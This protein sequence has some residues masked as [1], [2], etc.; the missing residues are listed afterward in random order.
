MNSPSQPQDRLTASVVICAYTLDRC[1]DIEA[2]LCAL[3]KQSVLPSEVLLIVDHN[4]QLE[5]WA[6]EQARKIACFPVEVLANVHKQGL[7]G[8]RNC[9]VAAAS[10]D[11]VVFLDDDAKPDRSWLAKL[12]SCYRDEAVIGVGGA[13]I[14][15]WP[16]RAPSWF[17]DEFAWVIGCSYEGMPKQR[18]EI[19]NFIGCNM[20][21][22]RAVFTVVA[23]FSEDLGRVGT[24]PLG[25]EETELCIRVR[26]AFPAA[27]LLYEPAAIVHHRVTAARTGFRY[28]RRRC[29]AEGLSKAA[30]TAM[31][32]TESGLA[33]ERSYLVRTLPKAL[34]R[35]VLNPR[36][37]A[38]GL[39]LIAGTGCT[40]A[41]FIRGR[42]TS[43]SGTLKT[44]FTPGITAAKL[45]PSR[46]QAAPRQSS[47]L[48]PDSTSQVS[49]RP[50]ED[51]AA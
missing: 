9:G 3:E 6:A 7:S 31:V 37:G 34:V 33:S 41:G 44:P 2:A 21:F 30:M 25:C 10:G 19:R 23:G 50:P 36:H 51:L 8:A 5:I 28:F 40:V 47:P 13:A 16:N 17:P 22:R 15:A 26:E 20:S 35:S 4:K 38:R 32:G 18:G 12:L 11:V 43:R 27:L 45:S 1:S 29:F 49:R 48:A 24:I 39:A 46:R 14:P 42:L